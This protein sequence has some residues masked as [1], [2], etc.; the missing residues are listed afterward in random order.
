[1]ANKYADARNGNDSNDGSSWALA[2]KTL[3]G[4]YAVAAS[5]DTILCVGVFYE[6]LALVS[7]KPITITAVGFA[8]LDGRSILTSGVTLNQTTGGLSYI[9]GLTIRNY[10]TNGI[11]CAGSG[12]GQVETL[13]L[14]GCVIKYCYYGI[15][16]PTSLWLIKLLN[17]V[18]RNCT[19]GEYS[20]I[21]GFGAAGFH[22]VN[23]TITG[24]SYGWY[25]A[26]NGISQYNLKCIF[27]HNTYHIYTVV[28]G[29][30]PYAPTN[31][32]DID[33][34]SGKC[35]VTGVDKL[36]LA[37]WQAALPIDAQSISADPLYSDRANDM[38]TLRSTTPAIIAG[39]ILGAYNNSLAVPV[40]NNVNTTIWDN[41]ITLTGVEK[42]AS[43][44]YVL[45]AGY[46]EGVVEF[47]INFG[48][49]RTLYRINLNSFYAGVGGGVGGGP[50]G[51]LDLDKT[52]TLPE[53]WTYRIDTSADGVTWAGYQSV[54]LNNAVNLTGV[55]KLRIEATLRTNA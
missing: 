53:T 50:S 48:V 2:K 54:N 32:N 26:Q 44:N 45:S 19:F 18:I 37:A 35:A 40:S 14:T 13:F 25:Q 38:H 42:D 6:T 39:A 4:A 8:V 3:G 16:F 22:N 20:N 11:L 28:A 23:C 5:S 27:S 51:I 33:F 43:G 30:Y 34:S 24:C 52:D 15:N 21:P 55:W 46:A 12:G 36:T 7:T 10:V 1:M 31:Y 47:E 17:C 49:Q 41:P 9:N 29:Y